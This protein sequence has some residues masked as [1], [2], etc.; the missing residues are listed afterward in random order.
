MNKKQKL[1]SMTL[2][3]VILGEVMLPSNCFLE[4]KA[5]AEIIKEKNP[6]NILNVTTPNNEE[7]ATYSQ[8]VEKLNESL[9]AS[10][11]SLDKFFELCILRNTQAKDELEKSNVNT[12]I[13][14]EL[15]NLK[16]TSLNSIKIL[17]STNSLNKEQLKIKDSILKTLNTRIS[18]VEDELKV[19]KSDSKD[20]KELDNL[21]AKATKSAKDMFNAYYEYNESINTYINNN[22]QMLNC[23]GLNNIINPYIVNSNIDVSSALKDSTTGIFPGDVKENEKPVQ[24]VNVNIDMN[25]KNLDFLKIAYAPGASTGI[26]RSTNFY[27]PAGQTITIEVPNEVGNLDVQIGCHSDKLIFSN[28]YDLKRKP[29]IALRKTLKPGVNKI[30]SKFGGLLYF[31]PTQSVNKDCTLKVSGVLNAPRFVI[32]KTSLEEWKKMIN[33]ASV[34][35]G[36]VENDN[37]I[38]SLPTENLKK[39]NN[40]TEGLNRW[41][42]ILNHYNKLTGLPYTLEGNKDSIPNGFKSVFDR[43]FRYVSDTQISAGLM[44]AGYPMMMPMLIKWGKGTRN[45]PE[46]SMDS[47]FLSSSTGWG[48]W[49]EVGHEFQQNPWKWAEIVEST[50]NLF[51]LYMLDYY[52]LPC[53]LSEVDAKKGKTEYEKGIE[54]AT[55]DDASKNFNDDS[56][57]DPLTRL[58]MFRQLQLAYGWDFYTKLYTETRNNDTSNTVYTLP[59]A[60]ENRI[61]Y[62]VLNT[63]KISGNNLLEFFDH[64][65]LKYSK[66][67]ENTINNLN[68]PKPKEE[69]WLLKK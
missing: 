53:R 66:E 38:I 46:L 11:E 2:G 19:L 18:Y 39:I 69:I 64:W 20:K 7:T 55:K 54:F 65:G 59:N 27:V 21:K 43:Q 42:E 33:G 40:P 47:T 61:N 15:E 17:E 68:L 22:P 9:K 10:E 5:Y 3:V 60:Q 13:I 63:C 12:K 35:F 34:P 8:F 56:Q 31:I 44:H 50:N 36:E 49:H 58:V 26:L 29:F 6:I 25:Y 1:I 37:I 67:T 14:N 45:Y 41:N 51:C 23:K 57:T 62:F 28:P 16:N 24:N 4:N 32:G 48:F 30:S 52:G